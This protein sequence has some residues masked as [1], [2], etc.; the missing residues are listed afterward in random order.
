MNKEMFGK[1][2]KEIRVNKH[3]TQEK[4]AEMVGKDSKHISAL[5]CGHYFP[6]Y[7][8]LEKLSKALDVELHEM[9]L[10][11]HFC[12]NDFLASESIRMIKQADE[13]QLKQIYYFLSALMAG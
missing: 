6:T 4:L 10:F 2:L 5:E 12:N 7:D 13:K 1:R 9:F 11:S 8:T 3:L